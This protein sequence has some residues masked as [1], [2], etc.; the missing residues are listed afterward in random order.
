M[1]RDDRKATA[2]SERPWS[3]LFL[4]GLALAILAAGYAVHERFESLDRW[5]AE[6]EA[7]F[8]HGVPV[9][10]T[11]DA[12]YSLRLARSTHDGTFVPHADDPL[13]HYQ[14]LQRPR[15]ASEYLPAAAPLDW[16]PQ[17]TPRQMPLLA[18]LI[19]AAIPFAGSTERAGLLLTPVLASLF[20]LP[21]FVYAWKI[22]EPAAGLL[23]ALT[24]AFAPVYLSRTQLGFVD[25]DCLNLFFP[26]L[27]SLAILSIDRSARSSRVWLTSAVLGLVL[28]LYFRWYEKA[29]ISAL[30]WTALV[31]WLLLQRRGWRETALA[32]LL[33]VAFSH[34]VQLALCVDNAANLLGRYF[35]RSATPDGASMVDAL[36]PNVMET[37]G[38]QRGARGLAAMEMVLGHG[39]PGT[40]GLVGFA[41]WATRRWRDSVPLL[42]I[43][44]MGAFTFVSGA[45]F[46]M[47]LAPLAGFGLGHLITVAVRPLVGRLAKGT[48][49]A[50]SVRGSA[51][52]GTAEF[53][54]SLAL[55]ILAFFLWLQPSMA[56]A[57]PQSVPAI[58][59]QDLL[60]IKRAAGRMPPGARVWTWWDRGFAYSH[61]AGWTVYHDGSAQYTPQTHFIADSLTAPRQDRLHRVMATVDKIG[62]KGIVAR[63]T[64]FSTREDLLDAL[65]TPDPG[66]PARADQFVVFSSDMLRSAD[67]IRH[68]AGRS[69]RNRAGIPQAYLPMLC[70]AFRNHQLDC[71]GGN[72]DLDAGRFS[73]G[74]TIRRLDV[75]DD[76]AVVKRVD[77]PHD[78]DLVLEV[79][80]G[81]DRK[82]RVFVLPSELYES[83]LNRMFLLGE[84]DH[85]L[86][87]EV[88]QEVPTLR[89][90][91]RL[92]GAT[93]E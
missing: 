24:G 73:Q 27:A 93:T 44:A 81:S 53:L 75:I 18:G 66:Q 21:L 34:P 4:F 80:I 37:V 88:Y 42:P 64:R 61:V 51:T 92:P 82:I 13:R 39:F 9:M 14:R 55:G 41:V 5:R 79:V 8:A 35:S 12:Y 38:E 40:L 2:G 10:T 72:V 87:E 17:R 57:T 84:Y 74:R 76:G 70:S 48:G 26:W 31:S 86:F 6:P 23:A 60:A 50:S 36:F 16:E 56:R 45:R 46:S 77:F 58:P 71:D 90:Y 43:L 3:L 52:P 1:T 30:Y 67:A 20:V 32:V 91:R 62:N 68:V 65:A 69:L 22:G 7:Y 89:V 59:A 83:N 11:P 78:S 47:Y 63:A 28:Y 85:T 54:A 19:V 15:D 33:C 25:T 29:A 49:S